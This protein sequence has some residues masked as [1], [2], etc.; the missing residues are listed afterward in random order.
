MQD[1]QNTLHAAFTAH[2]RGDYA[3]AEEQYK[4]ILEINKQSIAALTN[5][6]VLLA[7]LKRSAEARAHFEA[8]LKITPNDVG[9]LN[10]LGRLTLDQGDIEAAEKLFRKAFARNKTDVTTLGHIG[11]IKSCLSD[12]ADAEKWYRRALEIDESAD[13]VSYNLSVNLLA[14]GRFDEGWPLH[15]ARFSKRW[16]ARPVNAPELPFP[17]WRGENLV[18]KSILVIGEQGLGDEIQTVRYAA[19][20][21]AAGASK[22]TWACKPTLVSLFASIGE[23]DF[24]PLSPGMSV[25]RHDYWV[26]SMSLPYRFHTAVSTI[27]ETVNP[28]LRAPTIRTGVIPQSDMLLKIGLVWK[29]SK[30]LKNDINRS[31][32]LVDFKLLLELSSIKAVHFFSLQKGEGESDA[33]EADGRGELVDLSGELHDFA[34]TA[35]LINQLDLIITVD[36]AVAH[37]A[38]ALGKPVWIMLPHFGTDWR[39]MTKSETSAL[40]PSARLFRQPRPGR[41]WS[42]VIAQMRRELISRPGA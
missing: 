16:D 15:E 12:L 18:G 27:P 26:L 1:E 14:Q 6:G 42:S 34:N 5:Y 2:Q 3:L 36:T 24:L 21:A 33:R 32:S 31:A 39:W 7:Q 20:L 41:D 11:L 22:V 38:G 29:G 28:Y 40:Y 25:N 19:S 8:A 35:A 10:N 37:L 4:A 23:V 30:Q 13:W 9:L 17:P